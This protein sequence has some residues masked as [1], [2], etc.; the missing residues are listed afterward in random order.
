LFLQSGHSHIAD[1]S[2]AWACCFALSLLGLIRIESKNFE[3]SIGMA[4]YDNAM[5]NASSLD[6]VKP[7]LSMRH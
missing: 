4:N 7:S 1:S 5:R 3:E 6:I 2:R